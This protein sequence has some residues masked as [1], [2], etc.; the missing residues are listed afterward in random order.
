MSDTPPQFMVQVCSG[1]ICCSREYYSWF[2]VCSQQED[3]SYILTLNASA[4]L[5]LKMGY[6]QLQGK[7]IY[8]EGKTSSAVCTDKKEK[9]N[10]PH[11]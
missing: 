7:V 8:R 1:A 4:I 6:K 10:F 3:C 2:V 5:F 9:E 11:I